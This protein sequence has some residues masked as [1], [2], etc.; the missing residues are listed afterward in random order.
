MIED[1]QRYLAS[2][3]LT[4]GGQALRATEILSLEYCNGHSTERGIYM[5]NGFMIYVIRHHKAKKSTN[6]EF[7]VA[8]FLP[9]KVGKLLYYYL[10]YIRL[11]A[12]MLQR[13]ISRQKCAS[14]LL[15][16]SPQAP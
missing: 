13:E 6:H 15:F 10:V 1:Y 2:T 8:R 11:F 12:V 3:I 5:H 7:I 4:L 9:G 14:S 16:C